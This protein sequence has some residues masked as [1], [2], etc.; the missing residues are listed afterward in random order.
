MPPSVAGTVGKFE[1]PV[2]CSSHHFNT[3][4]FGQCTLLFKI[5][6][7]K[8]QLFFRKV[9]TPGCQQIEQDVCIRNLWVEPTQVEIQ[10]NSIQFA[11][12]TGDFSHWDR[13]LPHY[14][15]SIFNQCQISKEICLHSFLGFL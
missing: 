13:Q 4:D 3:E 8:S 7:I 5:R 2:P 10:C 6:N 14:I 12:Q 11:I 9:L 15:V 1:T